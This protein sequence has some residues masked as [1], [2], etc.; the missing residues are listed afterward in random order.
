MQQ[1]IERL[2]LHLVEA[3]QRQAL[4]SKWRSPRALVESLTGADGAH[5]SGESAD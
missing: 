5:R 2:A 4:K 3:E 1:L